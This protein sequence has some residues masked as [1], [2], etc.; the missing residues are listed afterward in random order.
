M[1]TPDPLKEARKRSAT[2]VVKVS[3]HCPEYECPMHYPWFELDPK[4][5]VRGTLGKDYFEIPRAQFER[6]CRIQQE[7]EEMNEEMHQ[8]TGLT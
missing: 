6:W 7:W 2:G 5:P 1:T 8:I 3:I 4:Y